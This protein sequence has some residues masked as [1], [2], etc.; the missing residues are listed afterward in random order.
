MPCDF[1]FLVDN[2][3]FSSCCM[4]FYSQQPSEIFSCLQVV[5]LLF[6]LTNK[7]IKV[8]FFS[9]FHKIEKEKKSIFDYF[10]IMAKFR[11]SQLSQQVCPNKFK[12]IINCTVCTSLASL[13]PLLETVTETPNT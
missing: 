9:V 7:E 6:I 13:S 5:I 11:F 10:G 12:Q 4:F 1:F 8:V 3:E 2:I